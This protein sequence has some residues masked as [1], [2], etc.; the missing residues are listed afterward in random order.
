MPNREIDSCYVMKLKALSETTRLRMIPHLSEPRTV[1]QVADILETD[2]HALYHH[3]RV[4][5]KAQ[6]VEL[7]KTKKVGKN[8]WVKFKSE[9]GK[10]GGGLADTLDCVVMG[11]YKGK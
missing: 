7:V 10:K 5:E 3:M 2:H 9:K 11:Y 1:K 4:L 6:I 8:C